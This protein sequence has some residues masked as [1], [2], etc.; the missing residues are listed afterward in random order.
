MSEIKFH[1]LNELYKR[2]LPALKS[3]KK[4][5]HQNGYTYIFEEDIWNCCKELVWS[6]K[7]NLELYNMVDDILNTENTI[8][9][10]YL[11]NYFKGNHRKIS[12]DEIKIENY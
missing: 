5:L 9:D 12:K 10:N 3:K 1:S 7:N 6:K 8:F 4:L 11:K 2:L